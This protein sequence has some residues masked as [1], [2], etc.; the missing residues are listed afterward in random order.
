MTTKELIE[1][2]ME[3]RRIA[4]EC[5]LKGR[6]ELA[7]QIDDAIRKYRGEEFGAIRREISKILEKEFEK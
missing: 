3:Q 6:A 1:I 2:D 7:I 4:Q 5:Y